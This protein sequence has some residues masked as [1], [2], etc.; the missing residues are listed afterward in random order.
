M[1]KGVA[2]AP[3]VADSDADTGTDKNAGGI[4]RRPVASREVQ[5]RQRV[6][7]RATGSP[8]NAS[9]RVAPYELDS[10][11]GNGALAFVF[12]PPFLRFCELERVQEKE[13][14]PSQ[15]STAPRF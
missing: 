4:K 11:W 7:E 13:R 10:N 2:H 14:W 1:E 12:P 6:P 8:Q 9:T 15:S 3:L 5:H